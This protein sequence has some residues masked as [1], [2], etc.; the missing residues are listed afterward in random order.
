VR[1]CFVILMAVALLPLNASAGV[2]RAERVDLGASVVSLISTRGAEEI[3]RA[4]GIFESP[5]DTEIF[6]K[7]QWI[8]S[9]LIEDDPQAFVSLGLNEPVAV[10]RLEN[11]DL[12]IH[13]LNA[14]EQIE[15][16]PD[17]IVVSREEFERVGFVFLEPG[18]EFLLAESYSIYQETKEAARNGGKPKKRLRYGGYKGCVAYVCQRVGC[19]GTVG[20]GVGMTSYLKRKKGWKKVSCKNPRRGDVASWSGGSGAGHTAIWAGGWCFDQG[21]F[22]PGSRF[23]LKECVRK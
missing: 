12:E 10:R 9:E 7:S 15:E 16:M 4:R 13:L 19:S 21:C 14:E 22:D 6:T 1:N 5:A 8:G 20:N 23:R 17:R 2:D 18:D 3:L 11:G